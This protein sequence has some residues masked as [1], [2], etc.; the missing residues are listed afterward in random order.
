MKR[1]VTRFFSFIK[2]HKKTT[3]AVIIVL[4]ILAFIFRPK[5]P[6]PPETQRVQKENLVQSVAVSG[7]VAALKEADLSFVTSGNLVYL[8]V[9]KG[10]TVTVG[11]TIAVLDQRTVLKNFQDALLDYDKQRNTFETTKINNAGTLDINNLD[12]RLKGVLQNNQ[13]DLDKA[14][15]SVELQDLARQQ[16]IL[17]SP[18][19]GIVTRT[20]AITAG[21]TVSPT[22]VFSVVDPTSLVFSMDVDEA[23]IAKVQKGQKVHVS[24]DA[25]PDDTFTYPVSNIDFVSHTTTNGGN[26]FTVQVNLPA[27]QIG[28]YRVGMNGNAEIITGEADHVLTVPL[29]SI[30]DTN[31]VY[32]KTAKNTYEKRRVTLGLENDTD[33]EVKN[34]LEAGDQVLVDPSQVPV[35]KK[36]FLPFL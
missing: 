25:Y 34:G 9:K 4:I 19:N 10:D 15:N 3:I 27:S 23:D 36:S 21:T 5:S 2:H 14:V 7:S 29:S 16:T 22:D 20:D 17:S 13:Y 24:L 18:I 32:V 26:A 11:Q 30:F 12:I 35:Q 6:P 1:F 8:G 33:A 31:A 28:K